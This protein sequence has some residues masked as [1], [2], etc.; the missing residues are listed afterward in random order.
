MAS[1]ISMIQP[2]EFPE[3]KKAPLR[4][5]EMHMETL[6]LEAGRNAAPAREHR[7]HIQL[8]TDEHTFKHIVTTANTQQMAWGRTCPQYY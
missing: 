2:R 7:A 1:L 3:G 4:P 5:K 8:H 6:V